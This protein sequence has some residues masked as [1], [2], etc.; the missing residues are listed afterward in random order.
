MELELWAEN[1]TLAPEWA[2]SAD[3]LLASNECFDEWEREKVQ[4]L[5]VGESIT[6]GGGAAPYFTLT[7]TA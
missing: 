2:G 1:E 5:L 3:D 7:R 6:Y 4:R